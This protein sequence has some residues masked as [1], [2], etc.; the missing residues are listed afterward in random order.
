VTGPDPAKCTTLETQRFVG[1][2][3]AVAA[4]TVI[5]EDAATGEQV[6]RD[7]EE[8]AGDTPA[9]LV[10]ADSVQVS[11]I[12]VDGDKATADYLGPEQLF[13]LIGYC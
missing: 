6:V 3:Q 11:N 8:D 5:A 12:E 2:T 1:Q 7:C 9:D 13:G 4:N 10:A